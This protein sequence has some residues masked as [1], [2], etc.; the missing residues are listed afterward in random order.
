MASALETHHTKRF[1]PTSGRTYDQLGADELSP[2]TSL[3]DSTAATPSDTVGRHARQVLSARE[4]EV[5][6]YVI[7]GCTSRE[8]GNILSLSP[9]TVEFHRARL[10]EKLMVRSLAQLGRDYAD[11]VEKEVQ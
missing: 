7:E 2:G 10:M 6:Y 5:L 8:I 9:R 11:F 3:R 4:R 1:Q